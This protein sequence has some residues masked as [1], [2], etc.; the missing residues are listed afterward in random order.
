MKEFVSNKQAISI[1]I[2]SLIGES[3]MFVEGADAKKD[4]WIAVLIAV[5]F[6]ILV[7][8]MYARL[9]SLFPEK[10]FFDIIKIC[11]GK[12]LGKIIIG[13]YIFFVIQQ[14]AN[15]TQDLSFFVQLY[16]LP[17]Y[18]YVIPVIICSVV[19]AI[20]AKLGV[21]SFGRTGELL[22]VVPIILIVTIAFALIPNMNLNNIQPSFY[23]GFA[24]VAKGAYFVFVYPFCATL[25]NISVIFSFTKKRNS[26]YKIFITGSLIGGAIVLITC[27][28]G[29]LVLGDK[30]VSMIYYPNFW[31]VA[32]IK[33]GT[34]IQ[35]LD[36]IVFIAVIIGNFTELVAG[37]IVSC[38]GTAKIFNFSDYKFLVSPIILLIIISAFWDVDSIMRYFEYNRKLMWP[39]YV[40]QFAFTFPFITWFT[41]EIKTRLQNKV[42]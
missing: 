41:A 29:L 11:F 40:L 12:Y 24:P 19:V 10:N 34:F 13:L 38:K 31:A 22:V 39:T 33:V 30:I 17:K 2:L 16:L 23:E 14:T 35:R 20:S 18:H 3:T 32:I 37:L 21:E 26:I 1:L 4:S 6:A 7:A 5:F 8:I 42:K 9:L 36:I 27:L 25:I 28:M 15:E